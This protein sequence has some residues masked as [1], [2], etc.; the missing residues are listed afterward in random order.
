MTVVYNE[1]E[2]TLEVKLLDV[3]DIERLFND[4]KYNCE[5]ERYISSNDSNVAERFLQ[6]YGVKVGSQYFIEYSRFLEII[7]QT[8]NLLEEDNEKKMSF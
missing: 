3:E 8:G 7:R 1:W 5:L 6:K 4:K 2:D